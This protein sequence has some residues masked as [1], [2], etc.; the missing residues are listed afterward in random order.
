MI[1][2]VTR[3]KSRNMYLSRLMLINLI[4]L[5]ED[6]QNL[7]FLSAL[8]LIYELNF[9]C[10]SINPLSYLFRNL[11][12][13]RNCNISRF[14]SLT[15]KLLKI[16][17][18]LFPNLLFISFIEDCDKLKPIVNFGSNLFRILVLSIQV[19][20]VTI[21]CDRWLCNYSFTRNSNK[22]M[23]FKYYSSKKL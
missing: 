17:C 2:F 23:N 3:G 22:L 8:L 9:H 6:Y 15:I 7:I 18:S 21:I 16:Q 1:H 11:S 5:H 13:P 19:Q 20:I 14:H 10:G 4:F 12:Q